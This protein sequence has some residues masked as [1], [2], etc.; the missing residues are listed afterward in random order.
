MCFDLLLGFRTAHEVNVLTKGL[1]RSS[2]AMEGMEMLP[3][4][5]V[6]TGQEISKFLKLPWGI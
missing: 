3:D 1:Q 2:E 5:T 6:T 4:M